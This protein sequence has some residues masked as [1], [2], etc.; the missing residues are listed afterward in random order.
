VLKGIVIAVLFAL[1][2]LA[3]PVDLA[4]D[5]VPS[6]TTVVYGASTQAV[7][8]VSNTGGPDPSNAV[9]MSMHVTGGAVFTNVSGTGWQCKLAVGHPDYA[10]CDRTPVTTGTFPDLTLD[11][12]APSSGSSFDIL[13]GGNGSFDSGVRQHDQERIALIPAAT[14]TVDTTIDPNPVYAGDL[15]SA[16]YSMTN[17]GP[18]TSG[19][20]QLQ[21]TFD[22]PLPDF[23]SASGTGWTCSHMD[24]PYVL[25]NHAPVSVNTTTDVTVMTHA[26]AEGGTLTTNGSIFSNG[27]YQ[28]DPTTFDVIPNA[29]LYF[30]LYGPTSA[31][32]NATVEHEV[33]VT[34][35]GPSTAHNVSVAFDATTSIVSASGMGWDCANDT[36]TMASLAPATVAPPIMVTTHAAVS[37]TYILPTMLKAMTPAHGAGTVDLTVVNADGATAMLMSAFRFEPASPGRRR[38]T[39]H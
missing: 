25:C 5:I 1:P 18:Q 13:A 23:V 39:R 27:S 35:G 21:I 32:A 28:D 3:Q 34:N 31:A 11:I 38:A 12:T 6:E 10:I 14:F 2:A 7:I 33:D 19:S 22:G 26:P 4:V 24:Y 37:T 8:H 36:C 17:T 15:F 29:E 9:V 20:L 16:T 30:A